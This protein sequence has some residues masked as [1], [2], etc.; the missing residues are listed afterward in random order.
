MVHPGHPETTYK[1]RAALNHDVANHIL[2]RD[3]F[4][5]E[6]DLKHPSLAGKHQMGLSLNS[7]VANC[8]P[9]RPAVPTNH[10]P[11]NMIRR[12]HLG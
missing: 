6:R 4:I 2:D 1:G 10:A 5:V 9:A 11:V 3:E 8:S 12:P 7:Q